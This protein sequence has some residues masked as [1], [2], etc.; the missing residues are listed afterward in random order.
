[1]K[2]DG[3]QSTR[4]RPLLRRR[5]LEREGAVAVGGQHGHLAVGEGDDLAGGAHER[6]DIGRDQH[7]A[8]ADADHDR[9][10]AARDHDAVRLVGVDD[11]QAVGALDA[12]EH[13][14]HGLLE[15]HVGL[16]RGRDQVREHSESVSLANIDAV[17]LEP[18]A[19]RRRRS[20]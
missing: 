10:A 8:V 9:R 14:A 2:S 12:G 3:S 4:E 7:L 20:R 15:R 6:G 19:Q 1:M 13:V 16:E 18:A 17:G 5:A 11:E